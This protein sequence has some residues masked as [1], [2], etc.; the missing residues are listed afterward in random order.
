MD[1]VE[2]RDQELRQ[3]LIPLDGSARDLPREMLGILK[4]HRVISIG[5]MHGSC[6]IPA[7][8][9]NL[10][11]QLLKES[12]S[13]TMALEIDVQNQAGLDAYAQTLDEKVFCSI[14][15][16]AAPSDDGRASLAIA[17]LVRTLAANPN[18]KFCAFDAD[19]SAWRT[20]DEQGRDSAMAENLNRFL[21]QYPS[22]RV[23]VLCGNVHSANSVGSFFDP[24]FKPMIYQLCHQ[25]SG[26][27]LIEP[28]DI[29]S[30]LIDFESG[31]TW[32][33]S[34]ET[35]TPPTTWSGGITRFSE[36]SSWQSFFLPSGE[37]KFLGHDALVFIKTLT[38]SP[39]F[40]SRQVP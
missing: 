24:D 27:R 23:L 30:I 11:V 16:F 36:A 18:I 32:S 25:N 3:N 2:R 19:I 21:H 15:H 35:S 28:E 22:E 33:K 38:A 17:A 10:A 34:S 5:E 40:T 8:V 29:Y 31:E 20:P 1:I 6:E 13:L 14:P 7:F 26:R 39:P 37:E 9:S 12:A 4:R